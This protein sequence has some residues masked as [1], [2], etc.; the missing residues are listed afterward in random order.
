MPIKSK[1][2]IFYFG[3]ELNGEMLEIVDSYA[4]NN[5]LPTHLATLKIY[6]L[7][8]TS[9]SIKNNN[10]RNY[11]DMLF[12]RSFEKD[13]LSPKVLFKVYKNQKIKYPTFILDSEFVLDYLTKNKLWIEDSNI[14]DFIEELKIEFNINYI[15][16]ERVLQLGSNFYDL[17]DVKG[18]ETLIVKDTQTTY[19]IKGKNHI[20]DGEKFVEVTLAKNKLNLIN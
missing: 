9:L 17:S 4:I 15:K 18:N 16:F 5:S 20:F 6:E 2:I 8:V 10:S 3:N 11:F 1:K 7:L 19:L 13:V 12:G 14:V